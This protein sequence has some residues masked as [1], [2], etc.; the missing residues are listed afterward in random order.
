MSQV[1]FAMAE[2]SEFCNYTTT[3]VDDEVLPLVKAAAALTG[4]KVQEF[5]S[6]VLNDAASKAIGRKPIKR[7]PPRPKA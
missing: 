4:L 2:T 1:A 5:V 3:K 7:K 6:N